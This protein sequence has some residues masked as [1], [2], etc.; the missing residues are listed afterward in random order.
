M[1]RGVVSKNRNR[2]KKQNRSVNTKKK[3]RTKKRTKKYTYKKSK[4][5]SSKKQKA[6]AVAD[7]R[8]WTQEQATAKADQTHKIKT[9]IL[10]IK[11]PGLGARFTQKWYGADRPDVPDDDIKIIA[12]KFKETFPNVAGT[13]ESDLPS[14]NEEYFDGRTLK[15]EFDDVQNLLGT[16]GASTSA[17]NVKVIAREF[18]Q[19]YKKLFKEFGERKDDPNVIYAALETEAGAVE[20]K[21]AE[22][23]AVAKAVAKVPVEVR[24]AVEKSMEE[25]DVWRF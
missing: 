19:I 7:R 20:A 24:K 9:L 13:G 10:K 14:V 2:V 16:L 21:R 4:K 6:G 11:S 12:H 17:D 8:R 5:R 3:K 1:K 25:G 22:A 18:P 15:D 23:A